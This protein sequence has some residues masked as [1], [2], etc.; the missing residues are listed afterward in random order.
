M[1]VPVLDDWASVD[2][3][4]FEHVLLGCIGLNE[5]QFAGNFRRLDPCGMHEFLDRTYSAQRFFI[6]S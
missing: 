5:E 1:I 2:S 4:I 6:F 3:R